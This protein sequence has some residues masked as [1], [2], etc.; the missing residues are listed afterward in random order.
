MDV[1]QDIRIS[2]L[3]GDVSALQSELQSVSTSVDTLSQIFQHSLWRE[4]TLD[5]ASSFVR[6]LP[7]GS[8]YFLDYNPTSSTNT[9]YIGDS[10]ESVIGT[11]TGPQETYT[12]SGITRSY[13]F[14]MQVQSSDNLFVRYVP[15]IYSTP[16]SRTFT[17]SG[18]YFVSTFYGSLPDM[19]HLVA[20]ED[21][22]EVQAIFV[23]LLGAGVFYLMSR[24]RS[25]LRLG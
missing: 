22:Y 7:Y 25:S 16:E 2:A 10:L 8:V 18:P 6:D 1:E 14:F 4:Q 17:R 21:S 11:G 5:L 13:T 15:T 3:E 24:F 23:C 20:E 19:A 12:I 9:L